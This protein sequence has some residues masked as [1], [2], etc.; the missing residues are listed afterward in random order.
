MIHTISFRGH[1]NIRATHKTTI[2]ITV[3]H[4]LSVRGDCIVGVSAGC[5]CAGLPDDLKMALRNPATRVRVTISVGGNEFVITGR[6]D[7]NIVLEHPTDI[8]IRKSGFTCPRT[9]AVGCDVASTDMPRQ[10]VRDLRAGHG[11]TLSVAA[12]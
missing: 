4:S 5:G 11:G 12:E 6:G 8:V 7:P 10:M 1:P 3:D 2:E 9:L